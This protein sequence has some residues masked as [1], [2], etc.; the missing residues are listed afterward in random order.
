MEGLTLDLDELRATL[1]DGV[2]H[3][4]SL[5]H[6]N[7]S[8]MQVDV[9]VV[10]AL[11]GAL[12]TIGQLEMLEMR[13]AGLG[14]GDLIDLICDAIEQHC[15]KLSSLDLSNLTPMMYRQENE[16]VH[17]VNRIDGAGAVRIATMCGRGM[18]ERLSL[19]GN[20]DVGEVGISAFANALLDKSCKITYLDIAFCGCTELAAE[21]LEA[22]I[23]LFKTVRE[24]SLGIESIPRGRQID[25]TLQGVGYRQ[26]I[27]A[28]HLSNIYGKYVYVRQEP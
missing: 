19:Y 9:H 3:C 10:R 12:K 8:C 11:C 17:P 1:E 25:A 15:P 13:N 16:M 20:K 5:R 26:E 2:A 18:L 22:A 6:L 4:K 14:N 23:P 27:R 7:I 21:T 28:V 24:L